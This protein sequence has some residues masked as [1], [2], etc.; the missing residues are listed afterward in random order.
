MLNCFVMS[1]FGLREMSHLF[2]LARFVLAAPRRPES[3]FWEREVS[4]SGKMLIKTYNLLHSALLHGQ[5]VTTEFSVFCAYLDVAFYHHRRR[6]KARDVTQQEGAVNTHFIL[7]LKIHVMRFQNFLAEIPAMTVPRVLWIWELWPSLLSST[8]W[9]SEC[10]ASCL[11]I[12]ISFR[13]GGLKM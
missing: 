1:L 10:G 13:G 7:N 6:R 4:L 5:Q 3:E 8:W 11:C 9:P 2:F 12:Y